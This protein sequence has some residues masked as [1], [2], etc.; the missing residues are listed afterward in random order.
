MIL[1]TFCKRQAY[2][3]EVK[4]Y[5]FVSHVRIDYASLKSVAVHTAILLMWSLSQ[6]LLGKKMNNDGL[7][8]DK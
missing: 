8:N 4:D 3:Q 5:V 6:N 7:L 1:F 2:S